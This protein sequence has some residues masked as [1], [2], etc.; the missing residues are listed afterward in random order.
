MLPNIYKKD[1]KKYLQY[2]HI[3]VKIFAH[4]LSSL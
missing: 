3:Q 4:S 1:K 2:K